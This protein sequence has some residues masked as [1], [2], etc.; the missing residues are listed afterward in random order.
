MTVLNDQVYAKALGLMASPTIT[1]DSLIK[2][3]PMKY[4]LKHFEVE[5]PLNAHVLFQGKDFKPNVIYTGASLNALT[6]S[7]TCLN[8]F[9]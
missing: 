2:R 9:V 8:N 1:S 4:K 6:E 7:E 5:K 3:S